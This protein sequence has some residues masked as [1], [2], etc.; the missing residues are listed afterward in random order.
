MT[1]SQ[2]EEKRRHEMETISM[3]IHLYCHGKHGTQKG[4]CPACQ[5]LLNYAETRTKHC[6]H[7]AVKTF[8]SACKTHCYA[9]ERRKQIQDVMRYSGPRMLFYAPKL[10]IQHLYVQLKTSLHRP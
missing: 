3:M 7:M 2:V 5:D 8:C 10:A 4:L 1:P 9:P 6:P